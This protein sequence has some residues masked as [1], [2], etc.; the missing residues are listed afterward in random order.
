MGNE[1]LAAWAEAE[2]RWRGTVAVVTGGGSGLGAGFAEVAASLEMSVVLAD[3]DAD[4]MEAVTE[5]IRAI[6]GR[7]RAFVVDVGRYEEVERLAEVV[8]RDGAP[9]GL[10]VNNAG[11]EHVGFVWEQP[12]EAWHRVMAVNLNGV[13]HGIRCFVPRML[14]QSQ[15]ST[16]L[17]VASV[18]ALSTG[19]HHA[20]YQVSKHGVLA[21]SEALADGLEQIGAPIRVAV[22]LPGPVRTRIYADA[23]RDQPTTAR[24]DRV[25][26][27]RSLLAEEGMDPVE[28]A[29]M[30]LG[31]VA[32]GR[33]AVTNR[34]DWLQPMAEARARRLLELGGGEPG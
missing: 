13:F 5:R 10:L 2:R 11:I 34:Q 16:V 7:C 19:A 26:E 32:E 30:M 23:N 29:R 28:A 17:N 27:M 4:R 25:T 9:L 31:Q 15:P 3:V 18:A 21:L 20:I 12:P 1:D 14:V 8:G 33:F 6:G 24:G 22:A